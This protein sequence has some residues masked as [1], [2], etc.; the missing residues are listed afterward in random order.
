MDFTTLFQAVILGF[1]EGLTEFIPVSSTGHLILLVEMLDFKGPSGKIFEIIIQL[2]AILAICWVFRDKLFHIV[3]TLPSNK[4]S[5]RFAKIIVLAF[6]PSL[7]VGIF[8]HDF[9]KNVLFS[10]WVVSISLIVGGVA[11]LVIERITAQRPPAPYN[12]MESLPLRRAFYIGCCQTIAM[13][14]GVSRSGATIMGALL[15]G[16][17]RRVATEFSFFLAIPTMLAAT[18][19]DIYKNYHSLSFDGVAVIAMGFVSA[20]I[21][22]ML[23]VRALVAFIS[24]HGFTPFAWYRL[25]LGGV[26][27]I[28]LIVR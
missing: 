5:Q 13:I 16:V 15:L 7:V 27:L 1:V 6:V 9:I 23:V 3:R 8:A 21:A 26:M 25:A 22:A 11:I 18:V 24:T 12:A 28:W 4:D 14:P 2:G 20:F 17:E 10:P 19:F